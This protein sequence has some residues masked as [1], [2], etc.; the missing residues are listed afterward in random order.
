MLVKIILEFSFFAFFSMILF[1]K[2]NT[3]GIFSFIIHAFCEL[4]SSIVFH[5]IC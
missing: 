2:F 4:I 1:L 3:T 5:R